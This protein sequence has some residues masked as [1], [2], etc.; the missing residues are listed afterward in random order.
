M[1]WS[2]HV[3][4]AP[5]V[6]EALGAPRIETGEGP[7]PTGAVEEY[8]VEVAG[9][10]LRVIDVPGEIVDARR[11]MAGPHRE[12]LERIVGRVGGVLVC[13]APP[14]P[15]PGETEVRPGFV[16]PALGPI[17]CARFPPG[18]GAPEPA[19]PHLSEVRAR[20][21]AALAFW[22]QL[23][24]RLGLDARALPCA[25]GLG[26]ADLVA[27]GGSDEEDERE[28]RALREA[29]ARV[30]AAPGASLDPAR[31]E[32]RLAEYERIDA[33]VS[34][35]FS[36]LAAFTRAEFPD[37]SPWFFAASSVDDPIGHR[38][39]AVGL[40]YLADEV[41]GRPALA[42]ARARQAEAFALARRARWRS[43]G[44]YGAFVGAGIVAAALCASAVAW[45]RGAGDEGE[46][47]AAEVSRRSRGGI[48]REEPSPFARAI[49]APGI[50][51]DGLS[52]G[53][54]LV[55]RDG[56]PDGAWL[57]VETTVEG[58]IVRGWMHRATVT[59]VPPPR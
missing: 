53:T 48:L 35:V 51:R 12:A 40:A 16:H 43:L 29:Y 32:E 57:R 34:S 4:M 13:V 58:Q 21:V 19:P 59:F 8:R 55:V 18:E 24:G 39:A 33:R 44:R 25:V 37:L 15:P 54:S 22:E 11:E 17:Y 49:G 3:R 30:F 28:R 5:V 46:A 36:E 2:Q 56:S 9:R 45:T 23:A 7:A 41:H 6:G 10:G 20:L 38:S 50:G 14:L 31:I 27:L 42:E 52:P 26:F 1:R 47:R